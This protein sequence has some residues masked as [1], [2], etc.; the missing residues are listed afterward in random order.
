MGAPIILLDHQPRRA[1]EA[2]QAGVDL[3]LSGRTH[4]GMVL[5]FDRVVARFNNGFDRGLYDID[6]MSLYLSNGTAMWI[7]FAMR[8]GVPSEMT[9]IVLHAA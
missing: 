6:G 9:N 3:Q 1:A 7:G 5:S 2:A 8:L 4:G